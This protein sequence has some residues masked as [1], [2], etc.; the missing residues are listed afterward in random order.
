MDWQVH[1]TVLS[2]IPL[3]GDNHLD[4]RLLL[5]DQQGALSPGRKNCQLL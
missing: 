2:S 4:A 3:S 5:E 1:S